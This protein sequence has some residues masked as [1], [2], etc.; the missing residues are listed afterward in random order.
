ME[1]PRFLRLLDQS[2][3]FPH[4]VLDPP[5]YCLD[6]YVIAGSKKKDR[7]DMKWFDLHGIVQLVANY[8]RLELPDNL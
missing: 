1:T 3:L 5:S 2:Q 4:I 7:G 8:C 6:P